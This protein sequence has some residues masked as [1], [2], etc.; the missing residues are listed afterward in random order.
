[1]LMRQKASFALI[2]AFFVCTDYS[3]ADEKKENSKPAPGHSHAGESF[4]DGPRQTAI[5]IDGTGNVNFPVTTDWSKGQQ[6]FNQGIGQLH[7]FW[8][9][10]AERTFRQIAAEDPNCAM[11]YWGMSMANWENTKRSKGFIAKAVEL[12]DKVSEREKLY[13]SAQES[14]LADEPKDVKKRRQKLIEDIENIIHEYPD[15]LEAKA[16][17]VV[18]LWQFSHRGIP[19]GSR[20]SIDAI[21]QQIFKE[22]PLHPAHH[23]RIHLWDGKK[24]VRALS[25]A[26]VLHQTAPSI[27]HMWHMSGHIYSKLKRY[28][29]SAYHQEASARID[30]NKQ[31][32]FRVLPDTIHNYAHNNEW[33]IRNWHYVG[34]VNDSMLMSKGLIDNPQHPKLNHYGKGYSSSA[35]GRKRL[36]ETLEQ[37]EQW[38]KIL[39]LSKTHYLEPTENEKLQAE[40]LL[41]IGRSHFEKQDPNSLNSILDQINERV[42]KYEEIKKKKTEEA[43]KK[44]ESEKKKKE[45]VDKIVKDAARSSEDKLKYLRP[46]RDELSVCHELLQG[47][48]LDDERAKKI[49]RKKPALAMLH[50]KYG[51]KS[52]AKEIALQAVN[53]GKNQVLPLATYIHV[54]E[55]MGD[56]SESEKQF[57]ILQ[58]QSSLI[59][60]EFSPFTRVLPI[61]KRLG[62]TENWKTDKSWRGEDF[63]DNKPEKLNHLGPLVYQSPSA[64]NFDLL[65]EDGTRVSLESFSGKPLLLIFYL[66]H[67]CEH[68]VE[69]LNNLSPFAKEFENSGIE[70]VAVGPE[71]LS[72]LAKAHN[73]CS[74]GEEGFP[75]KLYS[76]L[77]S[78]SFKDYRSYDD[79][80]GMPL[81]GVFLIDRSSKLRW[82]DVGP[83]PFQDIKFLLRE[84]K[85]L[86]SM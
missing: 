68:C 11:A 54:L 12:K 6:M 84:S 10:E 66:G 50:L 34:K 80:E 83:E 31:S 2:I 60:I 39:E 73:L 32:E 52:K 65:C 49:K 51:E 8:Y 13:I 72:E 23:F 56:Q 36:V 81:H 19:I 5:I 55:S 77:E 18:R 58:N 17:L 75:F 59:D 15:D 86:L 20:E 24:P 47:E 45:E 85:R 22:N 21:M 26:A 4:D 29:E 82:M 67:N 27:A 46:I 35:F 40:R 7:G 25:S 70:I 14:F 16:I 64:P 38:D 78:G 76:D 57:S 63:G 1:M 44:A 61:A 48:K 30:H 33:L 28:A 9:Y 74:S 41:V 43:K 53:D 71:K 42:S 69:Q 3:E 37:F 62:E 79:F